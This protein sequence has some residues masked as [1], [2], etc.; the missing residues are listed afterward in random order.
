[1]ETSVQCPATTT[2]EVDTSR[3]TE[4]SR[5]TLNRSA[6]KKWAFSIASRSFNSALGM[7][8]ARVKG[9]GTIYLPRTPKLRASAG[10][11]LGLAGFVIACIALWSTITSMNSGYKAQALAEWTARKD[12]IEFCQTVS[13]YLSEHSFDLSEPRE[14]QP[15]LTYL[16]VRSVR[17]QARKLWFSQGHDA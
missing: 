3:D 15:M 5:S 16:S 13:T 17:L 6:T 14:S 4:A 8:L 10:A 2:S 7:S 9:I 1:M 11:V 12:F